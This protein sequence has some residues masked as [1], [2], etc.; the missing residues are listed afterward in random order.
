M[1][2]CTFVIFNS[3]FGCLDDRG[4]LLYGPSNVQC[5]ASYI[6]I[7]L[8]LR[9]LRITI[10]Q[11]VW[12]CARYYLNLMLILEIMT[13]TDAGYS[14]WIPPLSLKRTWTKITQ[15]DPSEANVVTESLLRYSV[16]SAP[17]K[18]SLTLQE[19]TFTVDWSLHRFHI[20]SVVSCSY[21]N[22]TT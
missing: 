22:H 8:A 19:D 6:P 18:S 21:H 20:I 7:I 5:K 1:D 11:T 2:R 13:S 4:P 14:W 9:S 12:P 15:L 3:Q 17:M 16:P 10:Q